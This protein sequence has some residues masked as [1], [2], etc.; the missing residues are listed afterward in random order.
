MQ[1]HT[2]YNLEWPGSDSLPIAVQ[3]WKTIGSDSVID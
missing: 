3:V 1:W 2:A